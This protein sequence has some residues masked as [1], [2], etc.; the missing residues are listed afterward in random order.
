MDNKGVC[1]DVVECAYN[2]NCEK[3]TLDTVEIT[4]QKTN[5]NAMNVPHYC[6]SFKKK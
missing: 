2:S 4:N 3:C 1:C 5:A 6:K